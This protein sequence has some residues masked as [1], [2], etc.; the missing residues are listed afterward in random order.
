MS[1]LPPTAVQGEAARRADA[2]SGKMARDSTVTAK[3]AVLDDN[4]L[5]MPIV[6]L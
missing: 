2:I 5:Q 1:R 6:I 3:R 4:P